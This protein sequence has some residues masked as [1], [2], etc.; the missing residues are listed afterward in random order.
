MFCT[1]VT[2]GVIHDLAEMPYL[3]LMH[4]L[5]TSVH[6]WRDCHHHDTCDN[7]TLLVAVHTVQLTPPSDQVKTH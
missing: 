3:L 2:A 4:G 5:L 1:C 6:A 7:T